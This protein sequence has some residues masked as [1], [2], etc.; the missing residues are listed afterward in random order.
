MVEMLGVLAIIGVLSVGAIAGYSKAMFKYRLN[1]QSD[2]IALIMNMINRYRYEL[3]FSEKIVQLVPYFKKLGEIPEDMFIPDN[4]TRI[5]DVFKNQLNIYTS[6]PAADGLDKTAIY[7]YLDFTDSTS[8]DVC[9]NLFNAVKETQGDLA[10]ITIGKY[11][12]DESITFNGFTG[13]KYC[14]K[15]TKDC[16]KNATLEDIHQWCS[17]AYDRTGSTVQIVWWND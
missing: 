2:Q 16:L 5:Q 4:D 6:A 15:T 10:Y 7:Y 1:K 3:M 17:F 8:I 12:A 14:K 9:L 11:S 13:D